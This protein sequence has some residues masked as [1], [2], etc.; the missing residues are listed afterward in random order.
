[1]TPRGRCL[2]QRCTVKALADVG[3]EEVVHVAAREEAEEDL[4]G[5]EVEGVVLQVEGSRRELVGRVYARA[6]VF[7]G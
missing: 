3:G 7:H 6:R 2:N 4:L 5:N 1:M